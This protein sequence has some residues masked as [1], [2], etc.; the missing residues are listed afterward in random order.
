MIHVL[1]WLLT[2]G[3]IMSERQVYTTPTTLSA[4]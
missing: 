3:N 4:G 1:S 2:N